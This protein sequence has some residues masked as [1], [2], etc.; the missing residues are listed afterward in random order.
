MRWRAP[1]TVVLLTAA[2]AVSADPPRLTDLAPGVVLVAAPSLADP[3]FGATVVLLVD[4][5]PAGAYGVILNRPTD[6]RASAVL[7]DLPALSP[8]ADRIWLGGPVRLDS[9]RVLARSADPA[10]PGRRVLEGVRHLDAPAELEAL[11]GSAAAAG[12]IRF[13][14]GFAGWGP[15]QLDAEAGRGDWLPVTA[16]AEVVFTGAPGTLHERLLEHASGL[17]T[18][19]HGCETGHA[20]EVAHGPAAAG[21]YD[22]H[23]NGHLV[24]RT[25]RR[26][27]ANAPPA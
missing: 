14:A 7:P 20:F 12:E 27:C 24:D 21:A 17:W 11:L 18:R 22:L 23:R 19:A 6:T 16:D 2:L 4:Y 9:I 26:A 15:G 13:F 25:A 1:G 10:A 8:D 5:S 3:N